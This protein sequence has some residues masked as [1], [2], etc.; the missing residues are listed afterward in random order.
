MRAAV[1]PKSS[2][3]KGSMIIT[4]LYSAYTHP[5]KHT[6]QHNELALEFT[7]DRPL[8]SS[9]RDQLAH[10]QSY[11]R[12]PTQAKTHASTKSSLKSSP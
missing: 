2:M 10:A 7:L 8:A 12:T 5:S 1:F 4:S 11:L 3:S 6:C 9:R